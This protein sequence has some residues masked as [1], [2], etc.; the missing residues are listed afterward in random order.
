MLV[1]SILILIKKFASRGPIHPIPV[2]TNLQ[3]VQN[4]RNYPQNPHP[5][6]QPKE[7]IELQPIPSISRIINVTPINENVEPI[8]SISRII[9]VAPINENVES[10]EQQP[11]ESSHNVIDSQSNDSV[12][13]VESNNLPL[14]NG[15]QGSTNPPLPHVLQLNNNR[16]NKS[17][18]SLTGSIF[19]S[20][21]IVALFCICIYLRYGIDD[22]SYKVILQFVHIFGI[23]VL[24]PTIYFILNPNHFIIALQDLPCSS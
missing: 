12:A 24:P 5:T 15:N 9:N 11:I 20:V 3:S 6:N 14:S 16:Y 8:P 21:I 2:P 4:Q 18:I 10:L 13:P 1:G 23:S 22:F 17:M 7:A 19:V